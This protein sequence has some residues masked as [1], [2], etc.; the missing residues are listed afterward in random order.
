[1]AAD[2]LNNEYFDWLYNFVCDG[3]RFKRV[4]YRKLFDYLHKRKF[5]YILRMDGNR[6]DDGVQLRH[7]FAFEYDYC[8]RTMIVEYL[9][10]GPCSV[11]E[12][13]VA[14][15]IRCEESIMDNPDIGN[16]TE[17]WF[18]IMMDNL[19]LGSM[20]DV[21]FNEQY[22]NKVIDR[23]LNREYKSNG[24]G[25]LFTV[26]NCRRD[27]RTVEIWYQLCWYLNEM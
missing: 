10:N 15:A 24:E 13:L 23:F 3:R 20:D 1:M 16:R 6:A 14:L 12:M 19:G 18:W 26:R 7:R 4:S 5:T 9:D 21:H 11:L 25:G 17:Q 2:N 27:L 8:D 22:T